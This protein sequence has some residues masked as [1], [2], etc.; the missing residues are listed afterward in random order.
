MPIDMLVTQPKHT[1]E[2]QVPA[3]WL[4]MAEW[5]ELEVAIL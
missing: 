4:S 5:P 1:C 2:N 3:A